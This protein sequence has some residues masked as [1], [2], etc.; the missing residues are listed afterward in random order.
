MA[1]VARQRGFSYLVVL[2]MVALLAVGLDA[3]FGLWSTDARREKEAQLLVIGTQYQNAINAY[4]ANTPGTARSY[5]S[6]LDDLLE[7]NRLATTTRRYLRQLYADPITGR[8]NWVEVRL[9]DG[10]IVGVHSASDATPLKQANFA[11]SQSAF[12]GKTSYSDWVFLAKLPPSAV[13]FN[14]YG[15]FATISTTRNPSGSDNPNQ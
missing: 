3:V 7:D 1:A 11:S 2:I 14:A 15:G 4:Y 6:K 9:T 10:Q 8:A 13:L 5:P 12:E